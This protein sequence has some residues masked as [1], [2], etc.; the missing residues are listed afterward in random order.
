MAIFE[1][2]GVFMVLDELLTLIRQLLEYLV[3]HEKLELLVSEHRLKSHKHGSG[4]VLLLVLAQMN[5]F[6]LL[7]FLYN[8]FSSSGL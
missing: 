1:L 7:F 8:H 5:F 2:V 3:L 4:G 6:L